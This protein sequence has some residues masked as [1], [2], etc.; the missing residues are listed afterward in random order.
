MTDNMT[1]ATRI[2][3]IRLL[4]LMKKQPEY[5]KQMGL[6]DVSHNSIE[7]DLMNTNRKRLLGS[8]Q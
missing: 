6:N 7:E 1:V 3:T 8:T 2:T 4:D 5:A